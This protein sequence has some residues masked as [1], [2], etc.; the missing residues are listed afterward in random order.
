MA[1][2][3]LSGMLARGVCLADEVVI[4]DVDAVRLEAMR[5]CYGV[6]VMADNKEV[7]RRSEV[8]VLAVKPQ[9]LDTVLAGVMETAPGKLVVSIA[10][11]KRLAF[12]ESRLPVSR[13]V[14]VMPNLPCQV[15]QG[16]SVL[17][18]GAT[19]TAADLQIVRRMFES[20]GR[21]VVQDEALFDIVTALS[22][23]GPAFFAYVLNALAAAAA[24]R[25]MAADVALELALQ[26]MLGTAA[27]MLEKGTDPAGFMASVASRGGTTAAGLDILNASDVR[28]VLDAV[29][30]A[31]SARSA[32]LS[33]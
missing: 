20:C 17:C 2:A 4:S 8:V 12:F 6:A 29:V 30:A 15:G 7:M 1:E 19:A 14:R 33:S 5:A 31:A 27:V 9:D 13:W 3:L 16:M 10:A 11:G 25:G 32:A 18:G 21:V 22:G 23:S 28:T 26:T 24:E